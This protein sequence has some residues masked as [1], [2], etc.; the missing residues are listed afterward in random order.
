MISSAEEFISLR[1]SEKKEEYDRSA[2]EEAP[3]HV[4]IDIINRFP[5]YQKWVA[6]NKTVPLE[7]LEEL[8]KYGPEI[9]QFVA[10]KR[11]L[12][13]DLFYALAKD[14][15]PTVRQSIAANKKTPIELLNILT[16]DN[17][18]DVARVAQYNIKNK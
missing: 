9:R 17:D 13:K 15:D 12:S 14:P 18:D 11:K 16:N 1:D 2:Q 3:I 10:T 8:C 6:H 7:I 5:E 4:W